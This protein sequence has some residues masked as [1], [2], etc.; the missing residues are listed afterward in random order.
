M[1]LFSI[2]NLIFPVWKYDLLEANDKSRAAGLIAFIDM[3]PF[4]D[5]LVFLMEQTGKSL[6]INMRSV[7]L[8]SLR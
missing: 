7:I 8:R 3:Q 5:M 1:G 2:F 6:A 4:N